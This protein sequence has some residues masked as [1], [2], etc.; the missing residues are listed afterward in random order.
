M[1]NNFIP[2]VIFSKNLVKKNFY[3]V[4]YMIVKMDIYRSIFTH[5]GADCH[6]ILIHPVKILLFIPNVSIYF[7][8]KALQLIIFKSLFRLF[9]GLGN[10]RIPSNID[11]LGIIGTTGKR[12]VYI[13]QVNL[14]SLLFKIGTS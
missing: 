2:E 4:T 7:F 12:R 3:I 9:N 14:Y 11:F 13:N 8:F 6:K 5:N 1:P 10:K